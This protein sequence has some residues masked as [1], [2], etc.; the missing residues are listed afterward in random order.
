M[1]GLER[2][3]CAAISTPITMCLEDG[4]PFGGRVISSGSELARILSTEEAATFVR[5]EA[6]GFYFGSKGV[7]RASADTARAWRSS[8]GY[9]AAAL[10]R[11]AQ[12]H[13]IY[14]RD[15]YK[16]EQ[17]DYSAFDCNPRNPLPSKR[18]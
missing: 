8:P 6:H 14:G 7:F 3:V 9:A 4:Q 1:I 15:L 16:P 5:A 11:F 12:A 10:P 18:S 2:S 13:A 17:E